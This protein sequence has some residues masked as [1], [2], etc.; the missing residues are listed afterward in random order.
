MGSE[1]CIRDRSSIDYDD[2]VLID[3]GSIAYVKC[4]CTDSCKFEKE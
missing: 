3:G 2:F 1:M 4:E